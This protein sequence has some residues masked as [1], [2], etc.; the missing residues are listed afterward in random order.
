MFYLFFLPLVIPSAHLVKKHWICTNNTP[1]VNLT[2]ILYQF[3][4]ILQDPNYN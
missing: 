3:F 1:V 2:L 4:L